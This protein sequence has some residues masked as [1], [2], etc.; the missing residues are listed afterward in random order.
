MKSGV[1][2]AKKAPT[3]SKQAIVYIIDTSP[4]MKQFYPPS[5]S[6][7]SKNAIGPSDDDINIERQTRLDAAKEA[8][9]GLITD[10]MLQSK[11][12]ECGV[13]VLHTQKTKHH[14]IDLREDDLKKDEQEV[15]NFIHLTELSLVQRPSVDLLRQIQSI[16][17][18]SFETHIDGT[19]SSNTRMMQN[20]A[21]GFCDGIMLA[22]SSLKR[23]TSGKIYNRK[24][25]L[26]T[27]AEREVNIH[28]DQLDGT[29]EG[30]RE[31]ECD[32]AVIGLDFQR[33]AEYHPPAVL[34][35]TTAETN[36]TTTS[37]GA[38]REEGD[39]NDNKANAI[40]DQTVDTSTA[41][42]LQ[43]A[44]I[45]DDN[46]MLLISLTKYIGGTVHAASTIQQILKQA[47]GRRIPKS[48]LSKIELQIAPSVTVEARISL[49][50]TKQSFPSLKREAVTLNEKG[51]VEKNVLGEIMSTPVMNITSHWDI[52]DPD[53]EVELVKRAQGYP[54][55][56]DL[57]PIGDMELEGLKLRSVPRVTILGFA[58]AERIPMTVWMGPTRI[59]SGSVD[60][61]RACLAVSALAQA[62]YGLNQLA[63]C[64]FVKQKD[65]DPEMGI[66]APLVEDQSIHVG[67]EKPKVLLYVRMPFADDIQNLT[68]N[69]LKDHVRMDDKATHVCNDLID[70]FM[71]S[72]TE[73][74]PASIP[75]PAIRSFR[76][77]MIQ[78]AL[79][80]DFGGIVHGRIQNSIND[81]DPMRTPL[82]MVEAGEKQT[83]AFRDTFALEEVQKVGKKRKKFFFSHSEEDT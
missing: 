22:F 54:Y 79:D 64:T 9:I 11:T 48:A 24:I 5:T 34:S 66:L 62:L 39:K 51:E 44:M 23:K 41:K 17:I 65:S 12:N 77:T 81:M 28:W 42:Q 52:D 78:R 30:L 55:G 60:S 18:S 16:S 1:V 76:K 13:I 67:A 6:S 33:S 72:D 36:A 40:N 45:K 63:I 26:I 10:L 58:A 31:I 43:A 73:L 61:R 29:V 82:Q 49:S 32:L 57:I 20:R 46:E 75:N 19:D 37:D 15:T 50:T 83:K 59:V 3:A 2:I 8:L 71:L 25:I 53:V 21:G 35:A 80:S 47:S 74:N 27:D 56:S 69:P 38:P 7:S 14:L 68:M 4:S 70:A